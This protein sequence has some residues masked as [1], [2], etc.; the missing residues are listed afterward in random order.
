[1]HNKFIRKL[2]VY[3]SFFVIVYFG[4]TI[5]IWS[6]QHYI[7]KIR[8]ISNLSKGYVRKSWICNHDISWVF[9]NYYHKFFH[10]MLLY[11][12][13]KLNVVNDTH[14]NLKIMILSFKS[15]RNGKLTSLANLSLVTMKQELSSI[16]YNFISPM[17][18]SCQEKDQDKESIK[19][20]YGAEQIY[21]VQNQLVDYRKEKIE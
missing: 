3:F 11:I 18:R 8:L 14:P 12:L 21:L 9:F 20:K 1:M 6:S 16:L 17:S 4:C 19:F 5:L 7:I 15:F 10:W 13:Y 2:A